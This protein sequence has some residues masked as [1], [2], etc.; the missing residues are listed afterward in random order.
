MQTSIV[1]PNLFSQPI[2]CRSQ[3]EAKGLHGDWNVT[4]RRHDISTS[5][6]DKLSWKRVVCSSNNPLLLR[7]KMSSEGSVCVCVV[8]FTSSSIHAELMWCCHGSEGF[9]VFWRFIVGLKGRIKQVKGLFKCHFQVWSVIGYLRFCPEFLTW[10]FT[11]PSN[12]TF[13]PHSGLRST[14]SANI[15]CKLWTVW[16][17]DPDSI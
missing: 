2:P 8:A 14:V 7:Q 9:I 16:I 13:L 5:V 3:S 15:Y 1:L 12:L 6:C 17:I 10:A 11:T 4:P